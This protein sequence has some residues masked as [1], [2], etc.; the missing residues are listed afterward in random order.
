M[1]YRKLGLTGMSVSEIGFGTWGLGGTAYGPVNDAQSIRSL[2]LALEKGVNFYDTADL[3]GD[4]HAEHVLAEAF[5]GQRDAVLIAT[6]GGT[7]P[8]STF[9][10][11]QNF[12][13]AHI[14][15]ALDKSL[16]RLRTDYVDLYLLHSPKLEDIRGNVE[17]FDTLAS[18]QEEGKIRTWGVSARSPRDAMTAIAELGAPVVEVNFNIIDHRCLDSGLFE[19][20][21]KTGTGVVALTPLAFGYLSGRLTGQ[22]DFAGI[23][24][25]ANWPREQLKR[26]ANAPGLFSFLYQ[27]GRRT[28][29]QA[30]LRFC[31]EY[32]AVSTVIPGM[33]SE[34]EVLEDVAASDGTPPF[35][36]EE[37]E[38]VLRT[39]RENEAKLYDTTFVKV[40]NEDAQ[41]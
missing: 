27:D 22:E 33:M 38:Q 7:L 15:Q 3:Y 24:H 28:P 4:G 18:F 37:M 11:P 19:L 5:A 12:S 29:T 36:P 1:R 20:A 31:L 25:R 39:Y 16:R 40:Q 41:S 34:S 21:L 17:L 8:H 35:S 2:R 14:R 6:K 10:M 23:D 13:E 32:Q 9:Y 26:W 30:A